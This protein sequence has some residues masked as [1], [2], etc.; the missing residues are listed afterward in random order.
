MEEESLHDHPGAGGEGGEHFDVRAALSFLRRRRLA[1]LLVAVPLLLPASIYPFLIGRYFEATAT[2]EIEK[3]NPVLEIGRDVLPDAPGQ[4]LNAGSE[5]SIIT[6]ATSDAVL[7]SVLDGLPDPGPGERSLYERA[8]IIVGL[9]DDAQPNADQRR[10]IQL[11]ALRKTLKVGLGGGGDYILFTASAQAASAAALIA[12]S[13][14]ESYMKHVAD[15]RDAASYRAVTWLNQQIYESRDQ[16]A[17][18]EEAV[19][20]LLA[21]GLNPRA[22]ASRESKDSPLDTLEKDIQATRIQLVETSQ[23]LAELSSHGAAPEGDPTAVA[24]SLRRQERFEKE[25]ANLEAARLKFTPTHPEVRRLEEIVASLGAQVNE[26]TA[27]TGTRRTAAETAEFQKLS[28]EKGQL[29]SKL[30]VLEKSRNDQIASGEKSDAYRRY[31]RLESELTIDR[32]MLGVLL[33]RRNETMLSSAKKGTGTQLLSAAITPLYSAGPSR[34]RMLLLGWV[35]AIGAGLAFAYLLELLDRRM[36]DPDRIAHLLGMPTLCVVPLL[37][38]DGAVPERQG[39]R[40]PGSLGSER[41]ASL[42]TALVFAMR[43]RKI[44]TLLITSAV[45]GEGKTTTS[46]NVAA[47]FAKMGKRVVL[48]DADMRR[49]RLHRVFNLTRSPGLSDVLAGAA[50]AA[51]VVVRPM[52]EGFDLLPA[53][54][55]PEDPTGLLTSIA[56]SDLVSDLKQEYDLVLLDSPVLLAV[57]DSLVLAADVDGVVLVHKPGSLEF[58]GLMRLRAD[59]KTAGG[60]TLGIVFNQLDPAD[61]D[62]YPAYLESP[63]VTEGER[64]RFFRRSKSR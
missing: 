61:R 22:F 36:R 24:E 38:V 45:A 10:Q 30:R 35:G 58:R 41:Y 46:A 17:R 60:H 19:S 34:K 59:L 42:R 23:R 62:V 14:A 1:I 5:A 13:A 29:E 8:K 54:S 21:D 49:P 50:R 37:D 33:K 6:L 11:E 7:G 20:A 26:G 28:S 55:R 57:P 51:D 53:G 63:Y 43:H 18:K 3:R 27:A 40:G 2:V 47:A 31:S 64:K 32:E 48:V 44:H 52:D 25:S 15:R 39:G 9:L 56:W 12:N 4:Q 16:I